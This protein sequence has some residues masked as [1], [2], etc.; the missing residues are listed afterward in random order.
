MHDLRR[1][2]VHT[3]DVVA[4][5]GAEPLRSPDDFWTIALGSGYRGTIDQLEPAAR[6]RV[7]EAVVRELSARDARSVETNAV[8]AIARKS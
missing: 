1:G 8:Y 3:D 4:G 2:G 7:R 5:S 6:E